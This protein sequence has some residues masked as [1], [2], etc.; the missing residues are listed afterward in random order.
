MKIKIRLAIVCSEIISVKEN[1][2]VVF[3]DKQ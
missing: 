1:S 2:I 3:R